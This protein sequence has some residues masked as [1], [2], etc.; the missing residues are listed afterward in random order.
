LLFFIEFISNRPG[1]RNL[2]AVQKTIAMLAVVPCAAVG[3][4][5]PFDREVAPAAPPKRTRHGE[6]E[7][8]LPTGPLGLTFGKKNRELVHVSAISD[9]S[10]VQGLLAVGD[11]L[12]SLNGLSVYPAG[13]ARLSM[14]HHE[15][16]AERIV[17]ASG[18]PRTLVV[19]RGGEP[20]RTAAAAARR[21]TAA[22]TAVRRSTAAPASASAGTPAMGSALSQRQ[23][24][25][26]EHVGL[27]P[28][29]VLCASQ[30]AKTQVEVLRLVLQDARERFQ[31]S[32][33]SPEEASRK[34]L[35]LE[36]ARIALAK[37]A[38]ANAKAQI[39]RA[40]RIARAT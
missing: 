4:R 1:A 19:R 17:A 8:E 26:P 27:I 11:V 34:P 9:A 2:R 37:S 10:P 31:S 39:E 14:F 18:G 29:D 22:I 23:E 21:S 20:A 33:S 35:A 5:A 12:L 13:G 40:Q 36:P 30:D 38:L 3:K 25:G 28:V 6:L 15:A 24:R 7:L 16:V 32:P